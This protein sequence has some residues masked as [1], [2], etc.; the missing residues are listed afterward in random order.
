[1]KTSDQIVEELLVIKCQSGD[2]KAFELLVKRWNPKM[3][4]RVYH[5]TKDASASKDIVQESWIIIIKK[6][7][8]LRD[9]AAF[10]GWSLKIAT[11][12]AIDWIRANQLSRKR[13]DIRETAQ[14]NF[15]EKNDDPNEELLKALKY[16]V[17]QLP[18][19]QQEVIQLFYQEKLPLATICHLLDLPVGTV[20]SRLFRG[21]EYLKKILEDKT[22]EDEN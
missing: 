16:A 19:E 1:M 11:L 22:Q 13:E 15:S 9:P 7:K 14:Q 10:P 4:R 2:R 6:I 3:L 8:T 21:R 12:K 5:T 18:K 17:R 20:K